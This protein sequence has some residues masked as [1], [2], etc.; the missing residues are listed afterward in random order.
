MVVKL[1][2]YLIAGVE[3]A[4]MPVKSGVF[5]GQKMMFLY[6]ETISFGM[7]CYTANGIPYYHAINRSCKVALPGIINTPTG[8]W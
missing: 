2:S 8:L 3:I 7:S 5:R 6:P 4:K 1:G